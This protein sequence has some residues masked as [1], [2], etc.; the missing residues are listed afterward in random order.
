MTKKPLVIGS[1][2]MLSLVIAIC[3]KTAGQPAQ[4]AAPS[5][6]V[7]AQRAIVTQYCSTCHSD[8]AKAAGM[9]SARKIDFDALDIAHV[10]RDA[11]TWE[12]I[13]RKLRAGMMPPS[14]MRRPDPATYK[15]LV[16][17]LEN[18]IDRSAVTYM[19]PPG[20]HRLNRTEYANVIKDLFD[21]EID[22][23]KYL[24]S[25]DSTHGF[26]NMAG[27]LGISS[28]LVEAYVSAAQ[29]ISR[30]AIGE[31]ASP[32]LTVYR[33]PED[34]SQDYHIEGL[35]FGTRGGMLVK[36]VFPSDGEYTITIT[37]IFGDNMSPTG[38][39]SVKCEKLEVL[40]DGERLQLLDWQGSRRFG[41]TAADCGG[42]ASQ[43]GGQ[44]G[45]RGAGRG[46]N[47]GDPQAAA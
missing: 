9:D 44:G 4:S 12:R 10:S 32:S 39:G 17:W 31:A 14:G 33:T 45:G 5:D 20:L 40:L 43:P 13:V 6:A 19:P 35:P 30:L 2:A 41:E 47:A 8:K 42:G 34:T 24:P 21:L 36:H 28:T 37:P 38:F 3:G 25:D 23:A 11:E 16:A 27:T 46:T 15:G 1:L 29:K 7:A 26:D 22:A 18:E